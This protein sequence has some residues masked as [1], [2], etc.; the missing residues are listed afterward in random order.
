MI[1]FDLV[2]D[3]EAHPI[4][5]QLAA[6]NLERQYSYLQSIVKTSLALKRDMLSMELIKGLNY[7]ALAGLHS[8]AGEIRPWGVKVGEFKPMPH[9]RIEAPLHMFIDEVNRRWDSTDP[10]FLAAFVLWKLNHIHPFINGNGRTARVLCHFVLCM[11]FG[12]WLEGAPQLPELIR[13]VRPK[14][15]EALARATDTYDNGD[16]PDIGPLRALVERLLLKQLGSAETTTSLRLARVHATI[17]VTEIKRARAFYEQKL[18]LVPT[19][20]PG[21][22]RIQYGPEDNRVIVHRS[23]FAGSNRATVA[24]WIAGE[25]I[26]DVVK[27]LREKGIEFKHFDIPGVAREGDLHVSGPTKAAW[28]KDPD[29]NLLNI[30]NR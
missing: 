12:R 28:F 25:Q 27:A 4:Y 20:E 17:A 7:H 1:V 8:G 10:I 9:Y 3:E 18:G 24:T 5:Q 2:G 23:D 22:E 26:G 14:Y 19:A 11:K 13:E 30:V 16:P 6:E 15:V 21:T 29:G